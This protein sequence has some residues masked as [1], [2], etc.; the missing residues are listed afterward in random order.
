M[1]ARR[2]HHCLNKQCRRRLGDTPLEA[3]APSVYCKAC[4]TI[5]ATCRDQGYADGHRA[6]LS[7]G[8]SRGLV[9]AGVEAV[10]IFALWV[11]WRLF[12]L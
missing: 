6:G 12:T 4:E 7:L 10:V 11:G 1:T 2:F 8:W 9:L 3:P 5:G